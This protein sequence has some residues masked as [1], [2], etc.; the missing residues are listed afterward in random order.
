M[1]QWAGIRCAAFGTQFKKA[2]DA[3]KPAITPLLKDPVVSVGFHACSMVRSLEGLVQCSRVRK[4]Q[5]ALWKASLLLPWRWMGSA[6][7][8]EAIH[9]MTYA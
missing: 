2:Q 5:E 1:I 9:L 8:H 4:K 6:G 7:T 3:S